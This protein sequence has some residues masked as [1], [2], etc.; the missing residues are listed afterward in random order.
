MWWDLENELSSFFGP[1]EM[2]IQSE[3]NWVWG[4]RMKWDKGVMGF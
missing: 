1:S 4:I 2:G 3:G